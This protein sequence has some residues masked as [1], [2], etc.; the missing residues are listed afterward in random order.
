[1]LVSMSPERGR[2]LLDCRIVC[3][4]DEVVAVLCTEFRKLVPMPVDAPVTTA[5]WRES[6]A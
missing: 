5:S 1:M 2:R 3:C 4:D 6:D